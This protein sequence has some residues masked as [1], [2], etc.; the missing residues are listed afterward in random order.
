[1]VSEGFKEQV[2]NV[3]RGHSPRTICKGV[4]EFDMTEVNFSTIQFNETEMKTYFFVSV[5][6]IIVNT[7]FFRRRGLDFRL[8]N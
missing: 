6:H 5:L 7:T 4:A 1:M 2:S 8:L 3:P